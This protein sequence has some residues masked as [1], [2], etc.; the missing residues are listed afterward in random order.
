MADDTISRQAAITEIKSYIVDPDKAV[1]EY[2]DNVFNY[3]AG[4]KSAV[5]AVVDLPPA[6][7]QPESRWIPVEEDMPEF[8]ERVLVT[9]S[10]VDG[11]TLT[12][13]AWY[14][15]PMFEN[16]V[17]FYESD[18]EGGDYEIS[19]VIAWMPLPRPYKRS[20]NV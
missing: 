5:Q 7:P 1:S 11:S 20:D 8:G 17:C 14:G 6:Q 16:N 2:E 13:I 15:I 4:L 3:N 19:G 10:L 12:R 9:I 18:S